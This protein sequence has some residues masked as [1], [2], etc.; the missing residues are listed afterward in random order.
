MEKAT[1]T[2][3]V[4]DGPGKLITSQRQGEFESP[5]KIGIEDISAFLN[6]WKPSLPC[7]PSR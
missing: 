1:P 7:N 2:L 6:R 5:A 3:A 4:I